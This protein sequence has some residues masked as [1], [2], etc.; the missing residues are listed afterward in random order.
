MDLPETIGRYQIRGK[1]GAGGMGL[2]FEGY[3]PDLKR[4]VAIKFPRDLPG[5]AGKLLRERFARESR[6]LSAIRHPNLIT[7][8]EVGEHEG[9]P[10]AVLEWIEGDTLDAKVRGG[11]PLGESEAAHIVAK[12]AMAAHYLHLN[13]YLHRDIKP[14]N[15]LLRD[16]EPVLADLGL[17][18][19]TGGEAS[20]EA[21]LTIAGSAI[22]TPD[23]AAPEQIRGDHD[24]TGPR[25]DVFGLGA[26]LYF[27]LTG[28]APRGESRSIGQFLAQQIPPPTRHRP[29]LDA[30]LSD[31]CRRALARDP[32]RRFRSAQSFADSL[33]RWALLHDQGQAIYGRGFASLWE[34]ED[35]FRGH[36]DRADDDP[37]PPAAWILPVGLASATVGILALALSLGVVGQAAARAKPLDP[38]PSALIPGA[39]LVQA[40][41][42]AR[43]AERDLTIARQE[44]E[45]LQLELRE[46]E[47][48]TGELTRGLAAEPRVKLL[49]ERLKKVRGLCREL[50]A[51][52]PLTEVESLTLARP[53]FLDLPQEE[54]PPLP[55]PPGVSMT[56]SKGTYLLADSKVRMVWVPAGSFPRTPDDKVAIRHG[57]FI[58][59]TEI[60]RSQFLLFCDE[61]GHPLPPSL[62]R[63]SAGLQDTLPVN[64]VSHVDAMAYAKWTV[65]RLPSESEWEYAA[66]GPSGLAWPWGTERDLSRCNIG[67]ERDPFPRL[68]PPGSLLEGASPFGA[69][70]MA[71]NLSEW[72]ADETDDREERSS[73]ERP[74]RL[75]Q[76]SQHA[77]HRTVGG[78]YRSKA[79]TQLDDYRRVSR[80]EFRSVLLGFRIALTH[81]R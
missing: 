65:A 71:G 81:S 25:S 35:R 70:H 34:D 10:Y 54:R 43:L 26:T 49:R 68:A 23:Y 7:L 76:A 78:N 1:A 51:V 60:S 39:E 4:S 12:V 42:D 75:V 59:E 16:G 18:K 62:F 22:G 57:F 72:V 74:L 29:S 32:K 6:S 37:A 41:L 50:Q 45:A 66:R 77:R 44:I 3:E 24:Q 36:A 55:L 61:T 48:S 31:L 20:N 58:G 67:S 56:P 11:S 15:V 2:V 28:H 80:P 17:V 33:I 21:A 19:E 47:T 64:N 53:W 52:N 30:K 8:Y 79:R 73:T 63:P 69:L 14:E 13:G 46:I 9:Q 40:R 5:D 38:Q 27:L